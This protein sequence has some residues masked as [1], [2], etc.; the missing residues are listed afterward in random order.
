M[1]FLEAAIRRLSMYVCIQSQ[2]KNFSKKGYVFI[3]VDPIIEDCVRYIFASLLLSLNEST[4]QTRKNVFYFTS[5]APFIL[6]KI[7]F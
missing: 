4:G 7:K 3:N 6:E 5:K 2:I 1:S